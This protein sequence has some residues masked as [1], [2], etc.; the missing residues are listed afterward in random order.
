MKKRGQVTIFIVLGI[1][2]LVAFGFLAAVR[3][4][5][6]K[7]E[8][9]RELA[10][11]QVPE[12]LRPVKIH[13]DDC[14]KS[15][16]E[17]A[18]YTLSSR[19]GYLTIPTDIIPRS[20]NNPFSNSLEIYSGHEVAYWFYESANAIQKQQIP[21]K[22][23]M[24]LEI[25]DYLNEHFS[26]CYYELGTYYNQGFEI[27]LSPYTDSEVNIQNNHIEIMVD[28]PM[29]VALNDVT[30]TIEKHTIKLDIPLGKFYDLSK[31]IIEEELESNFLEEKTIDMMDVYEEIPLSGTD[32]D[33]ERKIWNKQQVKEDL[34]E[35]ANRNIGAL[36]LKGSNYVNFRD[37]YD[38]FLVDVTAPQDTTSNFIYSQTWPLTMEVSPSKGDLLLG[39]PI[40]Q[41]SPEISK[42][43]N[44]FFCLNNYNFVY[45]VKYPVLISLS[46]ESGYLFQFATMVIIDDNQPMKSK[47]EYVDYTESIEMKENIC[48]YPQKEITVN[49]LDSENLDPINDASILYKCS[50]T[51]CYIGKTDNLGKYNGLFPACLNG[52]LIAQK[53][54]YYIGE[55]E[56][57][58]NEFD[59]AMLF[60]SKYHE[61]DLETK[62]IDLNSG[63]T[64]QVENQE[65]I[66]QFE[67][68]DNDYITVVTDQDEKI[69]LIPGYYKVTSYVT[70]EPE[71]DVTAG[72]STFT[73][74][75]EVPK[76]GI[77]G[78]FLKEEKCFETELDE[79]ELE[80]VVVGGAE[81]EWEFYS[82]QGYDKL[83]VY[84]AI[85][86]LPEDVMDLGNAF[87]N[88]KTNYEH[89]NFMEPELS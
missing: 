1:V 52:Q 78:L 49:I 59:S 85:G 68:L 38:Y 20:I 4:N 47:F 76:Q 12:Q 63:E 30:K 74:C 23:S 72:G 10:K 5:L 40:T 19:G 18:V 11:S 16:S 71:F 66:F 45:D 80:K 15:I 37:T 8:F 67:N 31:K 53:Q 44:M 56:F 28:A 48:D 21:T 87:E 82:L 62:I 35:I 57:S 50:V 70:S 33:C 22:E 84:G 86:D 36:N 14:L 27:E 77:L 79:F 61:L 69:T 83:T 6:F 26:D 39:D 65:V 89:Y 17:T 32:F 3:F 54:N 51:T 73:Q 9:D 41:G 75:V 2:I 42:F 29:Y 13:I 46:D 81:F 7:T 25:S 55:Q 64:E 88:I 60:L 24:E 58:T 34:K 43:L